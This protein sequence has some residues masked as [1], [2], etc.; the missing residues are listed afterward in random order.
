MENKHRYVEDLVVSLYINDVWIENKT[1]TE[2]SED[3][4]ESVEFYWQVAKYNLTEERGRTFKFRIVANVD[5]TT[6]ELN[7]ENNRVFTEQLIGEKSEPEP[8]NWR[9]VYFLLS[10][11]IS[12]LVFYGIYRWRRKI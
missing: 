3:S 1:I 10:V 8:F 2:I 6:S 9:P 7:F 11:L 12:L 4:K 5:E